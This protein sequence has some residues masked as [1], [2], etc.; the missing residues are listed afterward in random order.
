MLYKLR[1]EAQGEVSYRDLA[2]LSL[3]YDHQVNSRR[4]RLA[5]KLLTH[6]SGTTAHTT[7]VFN[8]C[9]VARS[10]SSHNFKNF[11][12]DPLSA[13]FLA[14]NLDWH[15][16]QIREFDLFT[17]SSRYLISLRSAGQRAI[18]HRGESRLVSA[19]IP[20]IRNLSAIKAIPSIKN[21]VIY[22]AEDGPREILKIEALIGAGSILTEMESFSELR[23]GHSRDGL[24]SASEHFSAAHSLA[25]I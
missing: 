10:N 22:L 23:E 12:L 13:A 25:T 18:Q 9:D 7:R 2:P 17:G 11:T 19:I 4:N 3:M 21:G 15:G 5:I 6:S 20:Q 14:V 1:F 16:D 8:S 24:T